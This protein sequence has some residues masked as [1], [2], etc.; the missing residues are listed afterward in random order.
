MNKLL[1]SLIFIFLAINFA[2][3]VSA[4]A[5]VAYIIQASQNEKPVF[6][7]SMNELGLSYDIVFSNTISSVNFSN[8]K[9]IL[10]ND[11]YFTNYAQIPVNNFPAVLVNGRHMDKWGWTKSISSASQSI[12]MKI[13]LNNTHPLGIGL[14]SNFEIYTTKDADIYYLSGS[15]VYNGIQKIASPT[16]DSSGV[17][18]G[19]VKAGTVLT[20]AGKPNTN[21]NA[22]TVFF[23]IY[24]SNVWTANTKQLFK[25][26]LLFAL[27]D[28]DFS[29]QLNEGT[30]L[31]SIPLLTTLSVSQLKAE[32]PSITSVKEY[33]NGQLVEATQIKNDKAYF[34]FSNS[35]I[36]I[37]LSGPAPI[38][39]R[40]VSLNDGMN[41]IGVT[42]LE[43]I[44]FNTFPSNVVEV[45]RRLSD[46]K[47]DTATRYS[48]GWYNE[49]PLVP[50]E[51][52]WIK[53]QGGSVWNYSP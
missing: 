11:E 16:F 23:G 39:Q 13:N 53:S 28:E 10:L 14:P 49:F 29:L 12:K 17:V 47:Y 41:L 22:D 50:G 34:I 48:F 4:A 18:V 44:A 7:Q 1:L 43:N 5:D 52:Y 32:N 3:T 20:K 21:V 40:S 36:N 42:S 45:S 30:N 51:G 9:I 8:Y 31:V 46:G 2:F 27:G 37:E 26:S 19:A 25:N 6:T 35:Q 15:N 33:V 38:G 24:E